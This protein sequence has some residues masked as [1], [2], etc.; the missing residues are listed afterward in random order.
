MPGPSRKSL[1]SKTIPCGLFKISKRL[2]HSSQTNEQVPLNESSTE[3]GREDFVNQYKSR[4]PQR[5]KPEAADD[6][7]DGEETDI[8][9][10]EKTD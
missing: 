9:K 3:L 6:M 7:D 8:K 2:Q 1:R 10:E 5:R 4:R